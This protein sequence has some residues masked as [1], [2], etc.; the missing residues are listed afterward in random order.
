MDCRVNNNVSPDAIFYIKSVF[1]NNRNR[2]FLVDSQTGTRLTFEQMHLHAIAI[3]QDLNRRGINK[4]DRVAI[5]LENSL[6]IALI[7]FGCLY[8]GIVTVPINTSFHTEDLNYIIEHSGA[9]LLV[10]SKNT[11]AKINI[12]QLQKNT[13]KLLMLQMDGNNNKDYSTFLEPWDILK[14]PFDFQFQSFNNVF[15]DDILTI[16]Y[17]SGTTSKPKGVVHRIV[18]LIDNARLFVKVL[19]LDTRNRF[20]G[21]LPMTYL[22]GYYNLLLLPFVAGSSVV[23]SRAFDAQL[24]L[25]FWKIA[26]EY[27]VNTLWLV[28]SIL[29]I[30]MKID[31]SDEGE[32]FCREKVKKVLVGTAPLTDKLKRDFEQKYNVV[33]YENYGLSET[34]F[35]S[36]NSFAIPQQKGCVGKILPG[37]EVSILKEDG[38]VVSSQSEGEIFVRTPYLMKGYYNADTQMPNFI[39][40]KDLF[41][42]GDIGI[43]TELGDLFITGRKKDLIIR[44]GVNISPAAI[45]DVLNEYASVERGVVVGTPHEVYGEDITAVV[46]LKDE[47]KADQN[48]EKIKNFCNHRLADACKIG[49]VLVIDEFPLGATGKVLKRQIKDFAINKLAYKVIDG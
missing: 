3:A 26:K 28:P 35:I 20:Y 6:A 8:A 33:M 48:L 29:S 34:L 19:D 10:V 18:N 24:A 40:N 41:A 32:K 21:I 31:R 30:L 25:E 23:I 38:E 47:Y 15:S 49:Q 27:D 45:E 9:S 44:G 7:Y 2:E 17:T 37:V 22:G 13:I 16:I 11:L 36:S 5:V 46:K 43:I 12:T 1:D 14:L 39:D 4:G 42:T